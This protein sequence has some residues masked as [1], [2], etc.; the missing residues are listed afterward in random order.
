MGRGASGLLAN[1]LTLP[2][3]SLSR[4]KWVV[5]VDLASPPVRISV[6]AGIEDGALV[7]SNSTRTESCVGI[8]PDPK[9]QMR[10]GDPKAVDHNG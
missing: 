5:E 8:R 2:E 9:A 4:G 6:R 10:A 3:L 7:Y 1:Y